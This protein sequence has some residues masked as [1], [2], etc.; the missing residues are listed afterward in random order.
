MFVSVS[1]IHASADEVPLLR[2]VAKEVM[3]D[4]DVVHMVDEGIGR[5]IEVA[6]A[7]PESVTRRV[8]SHAMNAEEAGAEA[9]ML[10]APVLADGLDV[11]RTAVHVPVVRID[12]AM[13]ETAMEHGA[14]VGVVAAEAWTLERTVAL[15]RDRADAQGKTP[16]FDTRVSEDARRARAAGDL[17][18]YDRIVLGEVE[19]LTDVEIVVLADALMHRVLRPAAERAGVPVLASPRHGFEDLA[20]RLNYFRR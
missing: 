3:A 16:S 11:V 6:G 9:V 1:L 7:V 8:C 14:E 15:L 10:T 19:R 5:L 20:K 17:A 2:Q 13:A 4:V 12:A 18:A